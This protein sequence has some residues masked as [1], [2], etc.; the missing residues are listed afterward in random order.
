MN[1][2]L[3]HLNISLYIYLYVRNKYHLAKTIKNKS[4]CKMCDL[5][6]ERFKIPTESIEN[7]LPQRM[8]WEIVMKEPFTL[9]GL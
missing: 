3:M 9:L 8:A 7:A 6:F 1:N 4:G 2:M 5:S